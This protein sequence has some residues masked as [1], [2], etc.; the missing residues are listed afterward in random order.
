MNS[1]ELKQCLKIYGNEA[2]KKVLETAVEKGETRIVS[3]L[4]DTGRVFL[5]GQL[6]QK[7]CLLNHKKIVQIFIEK[8][9]LA[10]YQKGVDINLIVQQCSL[11][12]LKLINSTGNF[13]PSLYLRSALRDPDQ[14]SRLKKVEWIIELENNIDCDLGGYYGERPLHVAARTHDLALVQLI[15]KHTDNVNPIHN[16]WIFW[17]YTPLDYVNERTTLGKKVADYLRT[18]GG[19]RFDDIHSMQ[20]VYF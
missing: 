3:A 12:I 14:S 20:P 16:R 7:A 19:V 10:H 1:V 15:L 9:N 4:L 6:F 18:W 11:K 17:N 5:T 8:N 2:N 13:Y